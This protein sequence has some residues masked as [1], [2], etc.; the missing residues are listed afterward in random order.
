MVH[1]DNILISLNSKT[2]SYN[3]STL[4]SEVSYKF[5]GI[6]KE[7]QDIDRSYI[8]ILNAQILF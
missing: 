4:K 8:S 1:Q 3:N 5:T 6:L 7:V 2:A